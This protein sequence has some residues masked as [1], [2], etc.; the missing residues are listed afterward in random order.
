LKVHISVIADYYA[1]KAGYAEI[2]IT[3]ANSSEY[4]FQDRISP[5]S[6]YQPNRVTLSSIEKISFIF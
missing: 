2:I 5:L 1:Y 6:L 4:G 3:R